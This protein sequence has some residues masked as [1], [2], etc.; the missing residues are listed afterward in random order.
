[1]EGY[2][3]RFSDRLKQAQREYEATTIFG[4]S[5]ASLSAQEQASVNST[6][7]KMTFVLKVQDDDGVAGDQ[8]ILE[9]QN[10]A[11]NWFKDTWNLDF[12][13]LREIVQQR[14]DNKEAG[15]AALHAEVDA[16]Q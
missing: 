12:D 3:A 6:V 7:D 2:I 9:K 4:K 1:I 10:I 15:L 14:Q 13:K 8:K 11:R 16:I 5:F